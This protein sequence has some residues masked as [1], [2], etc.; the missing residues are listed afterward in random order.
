MT[1]SRR[2]PPLGPPPDLRVTELAEG[3][4]VLSYALPEWELPNCLSPA[5]REVVCGLLRG[6]THRELATSRDVS[7]R[8]IANQLASVF[9]KLGVQSR[10]ELAARLRRMSG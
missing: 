1:E 4:Q 5:E 7:E 3:M 8:T 9:G 2:L 10:L 6:M